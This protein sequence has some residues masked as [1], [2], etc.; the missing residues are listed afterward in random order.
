MALFERGKVH[1]DRRCVGFGQFGQ[2]E[3]VS[4][5]EAEGFVFLQQVFGDGLG[6][7][8]AIKSRSA[9]TDF[10]HKDEGLLGGVVEDVGGFAHFDHEGG[11]VGGK[12][13]RCADTGK[14]LVDG[15]DL[16]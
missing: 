10:V 9:A 1:I 14:D 7:G 8:E 11:A 13:I 15:A 2:L 5:K 3:I 16:G 12:V 4:S 6:K